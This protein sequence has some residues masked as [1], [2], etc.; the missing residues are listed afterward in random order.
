[1]MSRIESWYDMTL[2]DNH[3]QSYT[4][5]HNLQHAVQYHSALQLTREYSI[6]I[7]YLV[8]LLDLSPEQI[9]RGKCSSVDRAGWRGKEDGKGEKIES[10]ITL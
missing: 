8:D 9:G 5:H 3:R 10:I 1:M 7:G 6:S 2:Y 4:E